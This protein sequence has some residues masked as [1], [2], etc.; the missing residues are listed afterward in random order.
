VGCD[1]TFTPRRFVADLVRAHVGALHFLFPDYPIYEVV[2]AHSRGY[3]RLPPDPHQP[4]AYRPASIFAPKLLDAVMMTTE[5]L[6][7]RPRA[8]YPMRE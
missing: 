4:P 5:Q 3:L 1:K 7:E 2:P 6:V 8:S